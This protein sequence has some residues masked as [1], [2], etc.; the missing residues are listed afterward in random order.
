MCA[1]KATVLV[2]TIGYSL[3]ALAAAALIALN[4]RTPYLDR[5]F[6]K[7]LGKY[8]YAIYVFHLPIAVLVKGRLSAMFDSPA[9]AIPVAVA[10]FAITLVASIAVAMLSWRLWEA[11]WLSLKDRIAAYSNGPHDKAQ[12]L[13]VATV[14]N[15]A[16]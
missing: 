3:S 11:P 14:K 5:S 4:L 9:A 2:E 12:A 13:A 16:A 10:A 1:T 8:S 7:L 15:T 6:L